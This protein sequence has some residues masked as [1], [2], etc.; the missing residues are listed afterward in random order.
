MFLCNLNAFFIKLE[1][2]KNSYM[3]QLPYENLVSLGFLELEN[4][5]KDLSKISYR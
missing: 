4:Y 3:D 2:N 5:Y 1:I